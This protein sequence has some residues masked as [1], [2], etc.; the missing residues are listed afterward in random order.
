MEA[1][2]E[3]LCKMEAIFEYLGKMEAILEN[4]SACQ[5]GAYRRVS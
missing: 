4:S 5:S 3:Y 2:F 1:I